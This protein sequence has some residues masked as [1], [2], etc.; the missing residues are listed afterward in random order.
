[1]VKALVTGATGF[2]GS[3]VALALV[4]AGHT[5]RVLRRPSSRLELLRGLPAEATE[6]AIG[7]VM[8]PASLDQA[9]R[10]CAWVFHVAAVSDYWRADRARLYQV[11]VQGTRNVLQ[12]ARRAGV[13]RVI[14]TSSAAA[15]GLRADGRPSDEAVPFNFAPG[16]FAYGHSKALAEAEARRAARDHGQ[17]VVIVNPVVV[18]GPG[19]ANQ[20]SGSNLIEFARGLVPPLYPVGSVSLIDVRDVAKAHLAAAE[21][22]RAGERYL[23]SAEDL[24]IRQWWAHMARLVGARPPALPLVRPLVP[25]FTGTIRLLSQLGARLPINAD[26]VWLS[27]RDCVFDGRKAAQALHQ[28]AISI[29]QSL[30][31]TY[32]WYVENGYI[33]QH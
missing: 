1:M 30:E 29:R 5:A 28:P 6:H 4:Q 25:L 11:N 17:D 12:A 8:N 26:Q 21:R 23:L 20:I 24:S 15:V 19:D 22:G 3:H 32:R 2:V 10:G 18:M 16:Q 9:M 7:D 31:D 13:G 33:R 14:L 27:A